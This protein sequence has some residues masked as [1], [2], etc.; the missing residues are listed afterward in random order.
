MRTA[1]PWQHVARNTVHYGAQFGWLVAVTLIPLA[2]V[3][4]IEFTMP[5]WIALLAAFFL[6]ER[7]NVWKAL[8]VVL[9]LIGVAVIVRPATGELN[10]G[11]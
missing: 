3:I 5:I 9:G 8:A 6:G 4:A 1:R 2:Q 7:I 10:P 11:R